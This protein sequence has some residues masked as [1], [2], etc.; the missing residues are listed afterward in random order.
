MNKS[1]IVVAAV[2]G[3]V[4]LAYFGSLEAPVA[5]IFG[6]IAFLADVLPRMTVDGPGLLV[7]AIAAVLFA[8]GV[9]FT[10]R[11]WRRR[12]VTEQETSV[13]WRGRWSVAV[14]AAV[15]LLFT[16]G[17]AIV[18]T[19]HQIVW[20]FSSKRPI[21]VPGTPFGDRA[22]QMT[23]NNLKQMALSV[24]GAHDGFGELPSATFTLDGK[25]LHGWETRILPYLTY[26]IEG[27]DLKRP[28]NDPVNQKYFKCI[29][30]QFINPAFPTPETSNEEGY[31]LNHYSANVH[32]LG[33]SRKVK[34]MGDIT[35]GASNT[36][37]LGE[38]SSRVR[39][40]AQPGNWRDPAI[41]ICRYPNGFGGPSGGGAHFAMADGSVRFVSDDVSAEVLR[42]LSTPAGGETLDGVERRPSDSRQQPADAQQ[43]PGVVWRG[44]DW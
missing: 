31:G 9:H 1:A 43:K 20:L 3:L 39:P 12:P 26:S 40:W 13:P 22:N 4:L 27:I 14:I 34:T 6:W 33:A 8:A 35:D 38:V 16:A 17:V 19:T 21:V 15:F 5:L 11:A 25:M 42:A 23:L 28:W 10:G 41:G 7:A 32:V 2:V 44:L 24:H 36:L 29:I 18:G 37:L 30:R